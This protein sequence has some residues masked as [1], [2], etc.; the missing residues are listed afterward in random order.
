[1]II[2][3]LNIRLFSSRFVLERFATIALGDN[4]EFVVRLLI[5]GCLCVL[6]VSIEA[7]NGICSVLSY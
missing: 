2:I 6:G 3:W 1:M 4:S 7:V 5:E